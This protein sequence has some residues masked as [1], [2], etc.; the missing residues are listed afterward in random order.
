MSSESVPLASIRV[1]M[2]SSLASHNPFIKLLVE[3]GVASE[4]VKVDAS[5]AAF[6][7]PNEEYDILHIHWPEELFGWGIPGEEGRERLCETLNQW[8]QKRVKIVYTRH[9]EIPHYTQWPEDSKK[10]F[11]IVESTA[12][13]VLHFGNFSKRQFM[14]NWPS[15]HQKHY[16]IRHHTY[17]TLYTTPISKEEARKLFD[18][19]S[20][21]LVILAFGAFRARDEQELV[22]DAF[23]SL[24]MPDKFLLAPSWFECVDGEAPKGDCFLGEALVYGEMVPYYFVA[25]DIV[26]IQRTRILNSGNIALSFFYNKTIVGPRINNIQESLDDVNNFSF[27]PSDRQS[28]YEAMKKAIERLKAPQVN[29]SYARENLSTAKIGEEHRKVYYDLLTKFSHKK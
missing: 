29:G 11:D 25:A 8:R 15:L 27:N 26:F 22:R 17:D 4:F 16:V 7:R 6:W 9:D 3:D 24:D 12:D 21:K 23:E 18:I 20:D 1:L 2:T 5:I 10:L 14:E 28:V 13:A 19:G